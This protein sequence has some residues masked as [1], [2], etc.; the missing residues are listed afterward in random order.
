MEPSGTAKE[1][2]AQ[3]NVSP[4]GRRPFTLSQ[5]FRVNPVKVFLKKKIKKNGDV[6]Q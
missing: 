2:G 6:T 3:F 1:M 5:I 4:E